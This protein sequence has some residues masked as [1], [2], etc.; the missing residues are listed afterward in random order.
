MVVFSSP[1]FVSQ[2]PPRHSTV[3]ISIDIVRTQSDGCGEIHRRGGKIVQA[4]ARVTPRIVRAGK[5]WIDGDGPVKKPYRLFEIV[6][7]VLLPA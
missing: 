2:A 1:D 5:S 3:V 7:A 6:V 4:Q